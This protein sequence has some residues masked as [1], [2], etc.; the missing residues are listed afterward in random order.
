MEDLPELCLEGTDLL[1]LEMP[2]DTWTEY[3]I[4]EVRELAAG[5]RFTIL[6]AH[7]ERYYFQQ[8]VSVWDEFLNKGIPI[9]I[10]L[11]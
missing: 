8:P 3:T 10:S 11:H 7:I 5:G 9:Q 4:R 1:L 6:M 2:F